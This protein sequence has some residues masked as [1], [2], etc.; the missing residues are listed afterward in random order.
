MEPNQDNSIIIEKKSL[1]KHPLLYIIIAIVVIII[2]GLLLLQPAKNLAN[3]VTGKAADNNDA[4]STSADDSQVDPDN[5]LDLTLD[6]WLDNI[7]EWQSSEVT[8]SPI[9][10]SD[11]ETDGEGSYTLYLY[12]YVT[13]QCYCPEDDRIFAVAMAAGGN[14][15]DESFAEVMYGF[16]GFIQSLHPEYTTEEIGETID[17][18]MNINEAEDSFVRTTIEKDG[19]FYIFEVVDG[20]MV[21]TASAIYLCK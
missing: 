19:T 1:F 14:G 10:R 8:R 17:A 13:Y 7:N 18:L 11:L 3:I 16:A 4:P 15:T 5:L 21:I 20:S 9:K 12:E 6:E 2:T